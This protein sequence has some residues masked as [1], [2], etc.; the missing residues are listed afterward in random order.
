MSAR[1]WSADSQSHTQI[2]ILESQIDVKGKE[3]ERLKKEIEL[4]KI[5]NERL[6]SLVSKLTTLRTLDQ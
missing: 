2:C 3:I 5:E 6:G 1:D 4:L